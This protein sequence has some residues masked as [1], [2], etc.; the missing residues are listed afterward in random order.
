MQTRTLLV[1]GA[2]A[3][4]AVLLVPSAS[5]ASAAL[6]LPAAKCQSDLHTLQ[7]VCLHETPREY[8]DCYLFENG[9]LLWIECV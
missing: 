5:A 4:T 8:L 1:A 3:L 7:V 9:I 6:V 2:L